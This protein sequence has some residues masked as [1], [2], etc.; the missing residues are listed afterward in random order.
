M[1][2]YLRKAFH[3]QKQ[4]AEVFYKKMFLNFP[5]MYRKRPQ[6]ESLFWQSWKPP[7]FSRIKIESSILSLYCKIQGEEF[8]LKR[9]SDT[10]VFLWS[11]W[12]FKN[13]FFTEHLPVTAF[14]FN[15]IDSCS[16]SMVLQFWKFTRSNLRI[17]VLMFVPLKRTV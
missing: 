5:K 15:N 7:V 4:P 16:N 11:L 9:S 10:C 2:A 13:I 14:P 8:Y 3:L 1:K 17:I 6:S 12:I